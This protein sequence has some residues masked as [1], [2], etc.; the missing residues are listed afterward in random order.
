MKEEILKLRKKGKTYKEIV[1]QLGCSKSTIAYHCNPDYNKSSKKRRAELKRSK[2]DRKVD[3]FRN[4][5]GNKIFLTSEKVDD[6]E[7]IK[8][9]IGTK[10]CNFQRK[11]SKHSNKKFCTKDIIKMI[12]ENPYCYLTGDKIDISYPSGF[13]LDH[14]LPACRGGSNELDNLGICTLIS[15][16]SKSYQTVDEYIELCKKVLTNFGY[17]ISEENMSS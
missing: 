2:I 1:N 3:N 13:A 9:R 14:K 4:T 5:K 16:Q 17:K 11:Y 15:N 12:E 8:S 7:K 6:Y 10:I